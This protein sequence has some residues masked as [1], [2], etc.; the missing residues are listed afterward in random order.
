MNNR[1]AAMGAA[2]TAAICGAQNP[3]PAVSL[4]PQMQGKNINPTNQMGGPSMQNVQQQQMM[5]ANMLG[6]GSMNANNPIMSPMSNMVN[7]MSSPANQMQQQQ[8]HQMNTGNMMQ[9]GNMNV[10]NP[11]G[12]NNQMNP[13]N[14]INNNQMISQMNMVSPMGNTGNQMQQ[15]KNKLTLIIIYY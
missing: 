11:M 1:S 15:V 3:A 14:M 6:K 10:S 7:P 9:G 2:Q 8:Q 5:G 13:G 12:G 4:M